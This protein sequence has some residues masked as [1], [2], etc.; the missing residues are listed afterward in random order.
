M[1]RDVHS[2][3]YQPELAHI[4]LMKVEESI[5]DRKLELAQ[6]LLDLDDE[7]IIRQI[8]DLKEAALGDW[9]GTL[10]DEEKSSVNRAEADVAAGRV[11][12]HE[13]VVNE[14]KQ[15]LEE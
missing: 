12:S 2:I 9:W 11:H 14:L 5:S 7:M 6:W 1:N 8:E 15:W 4:Y 13:E 10:T 3:A